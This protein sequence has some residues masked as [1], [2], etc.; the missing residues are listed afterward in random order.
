M[1]NAILELDKRK[2]VADCLL[3]GLKRNLLG[4]NKK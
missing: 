4:S 1:T 2:E 3:E